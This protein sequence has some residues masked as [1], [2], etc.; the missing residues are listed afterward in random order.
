MYAF[1]F[2]LEGARARST[3][4]ISNLFFIL[5]FLPVILN[6]FG[7]GKRTKPKLL[8]QAV[9]AAVGN[10][11]IR[12]CHWQHMAVWMV[13]FHIAAYMLPESAVLHI[14]LYGYDQIMVLR[15]LI[16]KLCVHRLHKPHVH[17][18]RITACVSEILADLLTDLHPA[19]NGQNR[20]LAS[21]S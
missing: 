21:I 12:D 5:L 2:S 4:I 6:S 19:S 10:K 8:S 14:L 20:D 9:N 17:K 3:S 18:G 13:F 16:Q 15:Q 1:A 11:T 7:N